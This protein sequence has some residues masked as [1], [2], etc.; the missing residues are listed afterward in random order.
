MEVA[1]GVVGWR[2]KVLVACGVYGVCVS[3]WRRGRGEGGRVVARVVAAG[4]SCAGPE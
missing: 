4:A 3:V 1:A 2:T